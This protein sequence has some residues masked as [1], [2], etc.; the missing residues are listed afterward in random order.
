MG[1]ETAVVAAGIT[2]VGAGV[3]A[4]D[5]QRKQAHHAQSQAIALAEQQRDFQREQLDKQLEF[6]AA[7]NERMRA[8]QQQQAD[9]FNKIANTP[10]PEMPAPEPVTADTSTIGASGRRRVLPPSYYTTILT[11][12]SGSTGGSTRRTVLGG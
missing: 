4:A 1:V 2:A 8:I 3:W 9:A 10:L 5:A 11:S 7:E 6:Y 12:G